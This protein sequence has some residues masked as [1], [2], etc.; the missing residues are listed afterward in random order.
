MPCLRSIPGPNQ[1]LE[2]LGQVPVG[3]PLGQAPHAP[4]QL[5]QGIEAAPP[6]RRF[7]ARFHPP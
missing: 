4:P 1:P 3:V 5:Q 6:A 7:S 2:E